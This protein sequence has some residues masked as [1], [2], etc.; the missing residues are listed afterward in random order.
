MDNTD[1]TLLVVLLNTILNPLFAYLLHS[2]CS[3]I[4]MC[5]CLEIEREV[6]QDVDIN[7]NNTQ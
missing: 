6:L 4:K 3:T 2:R 1:Y 7:N 5:G